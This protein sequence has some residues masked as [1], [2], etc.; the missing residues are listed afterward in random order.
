MCMYCVAEWKL[1]FKPT[2]LRVHK[3][4]LL[5]F[6][7]HIHSF[8]W[9]RFFNLSS[10]HLFLLQRCLTE[11][12][13]GIYCTFHLTLI[14]PNSYTA[15]YVLYYCLSKICKAS[16]FSK[17]RHSHEIFTL[18]FFS[19]WAMVIIQNIFKYGCDFEELRIYPMA[20]SRLHAPR[21]ALCRIAQSR[22]ENVDL[23][24][25]LSC[26]AGSRGWNVL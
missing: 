26:L 6:S 3:Y 11:Q 4:S 23:R 25:T 16:Y 22:P 7:F 13:N 19:Y 12:R 21:S 8:Y 14:K 20:R 15:L 2:F 18:Q 5:S 9:R 1:C 24:L 17:M 10:N